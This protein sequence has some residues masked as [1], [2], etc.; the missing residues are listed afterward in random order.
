MTVVHIADNCEILSIPVGGAH[1]TRLY[2]R[3]KLLLDL[4]K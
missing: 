4:D 3:S 2:Q 1:E